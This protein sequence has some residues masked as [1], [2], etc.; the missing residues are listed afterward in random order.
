MREKRARAE[1]AERLQRGCA[2]AVAVTGTQT[3]HLNMEAGRG[4]MST[5]VP[6]I[7]RE[8]EGQGEEGSGQ[9]KTG[10]EE[11]RLGGLE[12][13]VR[14]DEAAKA[15]GVAAGMEGPPQ[16][17]AREV[18]PAAQQGLRET[19][20]Q[21]TTGIDI[22]IGRSTVSRTGFASLLVLGGTREVQL[23]GKATVAASRKRSR[24]EMLR[25]AATGGVGG[26]KEGLGKERQGRDAPLG[27]LQRVMT[28][29]ERMAEAMLEAGRGT[30]RG[31]DT[32]EEGPE[33][34]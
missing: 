8:Q 34:A 3:A 27:K 25:D 6:R 2:Q 31:R 11:R 29:G 4:E 33:A 13:M 28:R 22:D 1:E 15:A 20:A 21:E 24:G 5:K 26:G 18:R 12:E 17:D 10:E 23:A 30:K 19:C 32:L 16:Q 7:C 9:D 14:A